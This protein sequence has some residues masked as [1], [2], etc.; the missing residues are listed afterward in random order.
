MQSSPNSNPEYTAAVTELWI[1]AALIA[2]SAELALDPWV[3]TASIAKS[4]DTDPITQPWLRSSELASTT[5]TPLDSWSQVAS[6]AESEFAVALVVVVAR[7]AFIT[8]SPKP[9]HS[10]PIGLSHAVTEREK[11][12]QIP[13]CTRSRVLSTRESW[14]LGTCG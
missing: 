2:C 14:I 6:I 11:R 13:L 9:Q 5:L 8:G 4:V 12:S 3:G 10:L 1:R 7:I